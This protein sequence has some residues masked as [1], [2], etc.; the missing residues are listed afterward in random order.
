M[1]DIDSND[2]RQALG[3][4]ATGVT[5]VT[6][7]LDGKV[8]GMTANAFMSVSLKPPLVVVA[9]DHRATLHAMLSQSRRY[10]VSILAE[11]QAYLSQWFA[12]QRT[13]GV[14][15]PFVEKQGVPVLKGA[16]AHI[17][18]TV[19]AMH[20]AGDHTLYVGQ[21]EHLESFEGNPLLYY[22]GQYGSWQD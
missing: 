11:G 6:T 21:V 9:V 3:R 18:T 10:G 14:D 17:V 12:D 20:L 5:V 19:V 13:E 2:F 22:K 16:L 7:R 15:I 8:H 1:T 4:F